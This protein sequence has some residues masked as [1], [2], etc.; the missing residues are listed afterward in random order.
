MVETERARGR[1]V[2]KVG[3]KNKKVSVREKRASE[4][5]KKLREDAS[6]KNQL[7]KWMKKSAPTL[8]DQESREESKVLKMAEKFGETERS[9]AE[10]EKVR[11]AVEKKQK[12][13]SDRT[14]LVMMKRSL[15]ERGVQ[16][17]GGGES[18]TEVERGP[19]V[20][21]SSSSQSSPYL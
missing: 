18:D 12:E 9:K 13:K 16:E 7:E 4:V 15:F 10:R 1:E 5:K 8:I 6:Q 19:R 20:A 14:R 17:G 21:F 3:E 11:R 2:Q